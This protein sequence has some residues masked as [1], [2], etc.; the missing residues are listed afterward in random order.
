MKSGSKPASVVFLG[1]G[2]GWKSV[3]SVPMVSPFLAT[4]G[5]DV[6]RAWM[7]PLLPLVVLVSAW[8]RAFAR[9]CFVVQRYAYKGLPCATWSLP[10]LA[11]SYAKPSERPYLNRLLLQAITDADAQ[12]ATHVG[13]GALN[14]AQFLNNG[15]MDLVAHIPAGCRVKVV[16]GNTLTAA[17]VYKCIRN[18]TEPGEEILFTGATSSVG[19]AVCVRLLQDGYGLRVL[20]KSHERFKRLQAMAGPQLERL[21][22]VEH[23]EDGT[24]CQTWVLGSP[25]TRPVSHL[26]QQ[27][28]SFL[29]FAVPGTREEFTHPFAVEAVG[30]LSVKR[31]TCDLTFN[32]LQDQGSIPACLAA[33]IIHGL[34]GF[35]EHEVSEVDAN[36]MDRWLELA[37]KHEF[38]FE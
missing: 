31:R 21:V 25:L 17:V 28:T 2:F 5:R 29:E 30:C 37:N 23:Y 24:G 11:Y 22:Q 19:M 32:H 7:Y 13:L 15:G 33:A 18:R 3:L 27:G 1:H 16:H 8:C 6:A 9:R 35:C 20:T 14:K 12:G 10:V 4:Q 36:Q 38:S 26:V 34:E